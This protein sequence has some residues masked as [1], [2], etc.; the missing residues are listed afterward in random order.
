MSTQRVTKLGFRVNHL[1]L[2]A[3][4][5]RKLVNG[6][7]TESL[8]RDGLLEALDRADGAPEET[9][10]DLSED[11][12]EILGTLAEYQRRLAP[13]ELPD[14]D[15]LQRFVLWSLAHYTRRTISLD[16]EY[17]QRGQQ[18][19]VARRRREAATRAAN[20]AL[21]KVRAAVSL[22][23]GP[24]AATSIL[25]LEGDTP[26]TPFQLLSVLPNAIQRMRDPKTHFPELRLRGLGPEWDTMADLLEEVLAD[27][28][29]AQH[30]WEDDQGRVDDGR[31]KRRDVIERY[32]RVEAAARHLF[33]GLALLADEPELSRA[34]VYRERAKPTRSE[35]ESVTRTEGDGADADDRA[36]A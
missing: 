18:H 26:T 24:E 27:L 8:E 1:R 9:P 29:E 36:E 13:V 3:D 25:D 30:E 12:L 33:K 7:L 34:L 32:R 20:E 10:H 28:M 5:Q 16:G 17:R 4:G 15:H 35:P 22:A 14:F 19:Y 23:L 21:V 11:A 6:A 31:R 2:Q